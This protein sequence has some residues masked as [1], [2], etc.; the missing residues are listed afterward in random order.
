MTAKTLSSKDPEETVLLRFYFDNIISAIDTVE[1]ME[2]SLYS[3]TTDVDMAA[4]LVGTPTISVAQVMQL[5]QGGV[6]G[7][8]YK[9]RCTVNSGDE[10]YLAAVILPIVSE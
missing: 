7:N 2:L 1:A 3:G 4:M 10:T 6:D 5:V 9:L 8:E